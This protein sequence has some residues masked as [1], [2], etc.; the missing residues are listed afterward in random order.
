MVHF[1]LPLHSEQ[2]LKKELSRLELYGDLDSGTTLFAIMR[3]RYPSER[4]RAKLLA[5]L[6]TYSDANV[7]ERDPSGTTAIH[8]AM[9]VNVSR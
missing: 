1:L 9:Q 3:R 8:L 6:L 2:A 4:K 7:N 5:A